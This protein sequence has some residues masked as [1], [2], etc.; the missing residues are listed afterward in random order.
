MATS[1]VR[2]SASVASTSRGGSSARSH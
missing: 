1:S 2:S